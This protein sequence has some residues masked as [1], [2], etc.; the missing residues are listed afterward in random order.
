MPVIVGSVLRDWAKSEKV[1][2][3]KRSGVWGLSL[4]ID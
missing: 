4:K 2:W 3:G 1:R